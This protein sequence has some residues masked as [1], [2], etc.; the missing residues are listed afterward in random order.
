MNG[1]RWMGDGDASSRESRG[2]SGRRST[3]TSQF[4]GTVG[5]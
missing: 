5:T 2:G 4:V 3:L 1:C